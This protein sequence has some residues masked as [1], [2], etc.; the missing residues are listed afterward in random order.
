LL[1]LTGVSQV[2][3]WLTGIARN[4][5][6][7]LGEAALCM[8]VRSVSLNGIVITALR[9]RVNFSAVEKDSFG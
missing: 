4:P 5:L 9:R 7:S 3:N 8:A 1:V 2:A 6:Y